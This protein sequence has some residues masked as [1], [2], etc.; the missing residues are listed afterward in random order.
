M[1]LPNEAE[2]IKNIGWKFEQKWQEKFV[3]AL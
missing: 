2:F 1:P 3:Y